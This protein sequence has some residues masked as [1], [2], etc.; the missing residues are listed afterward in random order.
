MDS[1]KGFVMAVQRNL[2]ANGAGDER[3]NDFYI[4]R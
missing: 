2:R 4:D 3:E 1:F